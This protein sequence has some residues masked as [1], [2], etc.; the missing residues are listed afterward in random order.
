MERKLFEHG[1]CAEAIIRKAIE[2]KEGYE[3]FPV[4]CSVEIDGPKRSQA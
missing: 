3:F 4:T 1:H 2:T